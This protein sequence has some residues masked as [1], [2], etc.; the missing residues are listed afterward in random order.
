MRFVPNPRFEREIVTGP[1]MR[2]FLES[3]AQEALSYFVE[4]APE[5]SGDYV[6]S[7]RAFSTVEAGRAVGRLAVD[8]FK[9][10]WIE[11]GTVDTPTFAPL[12]KALDATPGIRV[13]STA[14]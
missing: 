13:V 5:R 1:R 9:W 4:F 12:R 10:H 8:D 7:A 11:F 6:R 2:D 14:R 3:K